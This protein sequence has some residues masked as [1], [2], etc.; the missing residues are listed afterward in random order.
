MINGNKEE[1][2]EG[3]KIM[4][5]DNNMIILNSLEKCPRNIGK[6][7]SIMYYSMIGE[8]EKGVEIIITYENKEI[9]PYQMRRSDGISHQIFPDQ[10]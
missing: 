9:S 7:K 8:D 3:G 2:S 1:I 4:I 10:M 6:E 5:K